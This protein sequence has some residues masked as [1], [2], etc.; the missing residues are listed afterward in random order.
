MN[1]L[2]KLGNITITVTSA[3]GT[4]IGYRKIGDGSGLVLLHAGMLAS[5]HF[6]PVQ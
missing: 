1:R 3:D 2:D 4:A 6:M 5:Q